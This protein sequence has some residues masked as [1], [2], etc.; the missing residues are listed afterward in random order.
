MI[1]FNSKCVCE[2]CSLKLF[3]YETKEIWGKSKSKAH[4]KLKVRFLILINHCYNANKRDFKWGDF[5]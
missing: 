4:L 2:I 5:K 1:S 3:F